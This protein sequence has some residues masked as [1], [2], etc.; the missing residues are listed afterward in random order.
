[1]GA[2]AVATRNQPVMSPVLVMIQEKYPNYHPLLSIAKIAHDSDDERVQLDCHKTLAK[3]I[4]PELKSIEVKPP[5]DNR[6]VTVS[7]FDVIEE[8]DYVPETP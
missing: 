7:L 8:A 6:M 5:R 4:A 2:L 1:M 3:F